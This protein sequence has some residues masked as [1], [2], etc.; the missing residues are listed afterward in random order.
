MT[1]RA[2]DLLIV[3][4]LNA[5]ILV[6]GDTV[7][8]FG[9]AEK[10]VD[11]ITVTGG[12]SAAIA[13]S[14]A[15]RLGL[16]VLYASVVGDD[17]LGN[18]MIGVMQATGVDVSHVVIDPHVATGATIHLLREGGDRAMLTHLGSIA[19]ITP[20]LIDPGWYDA[21]RHLHLVSPFLLS[22]L[23][24]GM[25]AMAKT[26]HR[27]GMTVSLDTNW[28]PAETW[29]LVSLLEHV[30]ILFP[31]EAELR[32]LSGQTDLDT[33]I[34][35]MLGRVPVLAVKRGACGATGAQGTQRV[36]EPAFQVT[37]VDATGAGD[38]FDAGFLAAWL[39][40]ATLAQ[41]LLVASAAAALGTTAC[42]GFDGQP[43]WATVLSVIAAQAPPHHASI[44]A[45]P[46]LY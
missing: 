2:Y 42:G 7:P 45:L 29:N 37:A 44:R 19:C 18:Y 36:H 15:S 1:P 12:G 26:A 22:G 40:G 3:G 16:R 33:A 31:N 14:A 32:A 10:L 17:L 4:E 46:A 8:V 28:D 13:A 23:F 11:T 21:A 39:R 27:H 25:E 34:E 35:V 20:D 41:S 5:D 24:P 30:D 6:T 9:Q 38:T 43:D